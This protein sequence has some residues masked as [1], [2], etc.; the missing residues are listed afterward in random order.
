MAPRLIQ[1]DYIVTKKKKKKKTSRKRRGPIPVCTRALTV[2]RQLVC[3]LHSQ[4]IPNDRGDI[5]KEHSCVRFYRKPKWYAGRALRRFA[6][7]LVWQ[8]VLWD[9]LASPSCTFRYH[10]WIIISTSDR[11]QKVHFHSH[12]HRI[13]P[14]MFSITVLA[15]VALQRSQVIL[16]KFIT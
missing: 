2:C 7:R 6:A 8:H 5:D 11:S 10:W 9:D 3:E 15:H 1:S 13:H 16:I 12:G 4:H 14:H